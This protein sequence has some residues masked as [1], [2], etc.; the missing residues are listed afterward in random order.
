MALYTTPL[1]RGSPAG[2]TWLSTAKEARATARH[3]WSLVSPNEGLSCFSPVLIV[4]MIAPPAA[5]LHTATGSHL[6][7]ESSCPRRWDLRP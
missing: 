3:T 2:V 6:A 5:T 7:L 4:A 1:D